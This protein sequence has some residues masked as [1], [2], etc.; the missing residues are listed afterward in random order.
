MASYYVWH[1]ASGANTGASWADAYP[2]MQ[3]ALTGKAA[4]DV[5]YVAQDHSQSLAGA[6][7]LNFPGTET[8]PSRVYCV[9]RA[10]SVPPVS[11]DLR[12]TASIASTGNTTISI[13]GSLS[14][15]Y[16]ISFISGVGGT[17]GG[18]ILLGSANRTQRFVNCLMNINSS[19]TTAR[20]TLNSGPGSLVIFEGTSVKFASASQRMVVGTKFIWRNAIA[21][22]AGGVVPGY[23]MQVDGYC[24][25]EGVDLVAETGGLLENNFGNNGIIIFKDCKLASAVPIMSSPA[26]LMVGVA[27]LQLVRC[28]SGDTNYRTERHGFTGV[29]T[30]ETTIVRTGGAS[31]GTTPIAWKVVTGAGSRWEFP[32][33]CVPISIWNEVVGS[34]VTIT[35]QGI[36]GGGAVPLNDEIWMDVAYLGT[37]G[38]PLGVKATSGKADGLATAASLPAGSGTWGGSTT[39]FA[40]VATF[41]PQEKGPITLT[42]KAAKASSTFY[43]DPKP[44]V[45]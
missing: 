33:E 36:W 30:T 25:L 20:L 9:N 35:L 44:A 32:F 43:I 23:L 15:C 34:P 6:V 28:D 18:S 8:N 3:L 5:F 21:L 29:L 42:V 22:G 37:S 31:D 26:A 17:T 12:T 1:A 38:F 7:T 19:A 10:G 4:G 2:S 16:G 40:L 45:G 39:K 27:D 13:S 24:L 11:A 41:T 14:E